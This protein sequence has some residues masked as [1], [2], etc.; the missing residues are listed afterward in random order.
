M[1][2]FFRDLKNHLQNLQDRLHFSNLKT[3]TQISLKFTLF[4]ILQVLLFSLLA[5]GIFFQNRYKKQEALI[6][7]RPNPVMMQKMV[8]GKN[9]MPETEIFPINSP[10]GQ[11]LLTFHRRKDIA[12]VDDMYFMYKQVNNQLLV[13]NIT[14]HMTVQKNLI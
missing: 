1:T 10:E 12:K 4:T 9:R 11:I 14:Q 6:P 5:N 13:T 8:L 2:K 3:S 7:L